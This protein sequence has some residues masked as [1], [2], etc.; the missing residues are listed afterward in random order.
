MN[1]YPALR[2]KMGDW[3]PYYIAKMRMKELAHEVRFAYEVEQDRTLDEVIQRDLN[4]IRV[5][6][7]LISFLAYR[8]DRFFGAIVVAAV[9]GHPKFFPVKVTDDPRFEMLGGEG[10]LDEAF[11]VLKFSGEQKYYALDGQHRLRAIQALVDHD[12]G[13]P[14]PPHG[15]EDEEISILMVLP[16]EDISVSDFRASYR[17]LF[18]SLNRYTKRTD[19]DTNIIMDED[20]IAA[21]LT[22][23]LINDHPFFQCPGRQKESAR[24]KTKGKNMKTGE[25]HFTSL[26]TLYKMNIDLLLAAWRRNSDTS[27]D[28]ELYKNFKNFIKYR[29]NEEYIDRLYNEIVIYWE[30]ILD[31]IPDLNADPTK[32]RVH[33]LDPKDENS[34][35]DHFLF[36]PIGQLM[37]ASLVRS[38][39]NYASLTPEKLTKDSVIKELKTLA[40]ID[41][42]LHHYPWRYFLI[43][44]GKKPN[45][46][47]MRSEDRIE[48]L[49]VAN[50]LIRWMLT[51]DPL[52]EESVEAL[53]NDWIKRLSPP[54]A[55]ELTPENIEKMWEAVVEK[56]SE[57]AKLEY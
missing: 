6:R 38:I 25:P 1:L 53:K 56:R 24:I 21:I 7:D 40:H 55:P 57:I 35:R 3:Q 49:K 17:R 13:S 44:P 43:V 15:F 47:I 16:P 9:G 10:G 36:W 19:E 34:G 54:Q 45:S 8:P 51:I 33:D 46:W 41:W 26:Q 27:D 32:M 2:A 52:P 11:G 23:R 4:N 37:F 30:G 50:R 5:K 31:A 20:D 48:V 28:R 14:E 42:E 29:P 18:S 12:P 39:L 22:R